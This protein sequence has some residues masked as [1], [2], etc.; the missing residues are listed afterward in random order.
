M[1][2][3]QVISGQNINA[4]QLDLV[5]ADA[6]GAGSLLVHQQLGAIALPTNPSNT[7]TLTLDINGTNVVITFVTSIGS[8]P[9]NVLISGV[10]A[11]ATCANLVAL[12]NQPQTTTATGVA[13]S[14]ANQTLVGYLS[15]PLAGTTITP[16]S[17]N[18]TLYAPETSFSAS[19][20]AT[21]GS[22]TAQ[23][24]QLYVEPGVFYIAGT[25]V[26]FAGGSTPTVTAPS[27]HPRIDVLSINASGTLSWTAGTENASPVAPTYPNPASN[28]VLCELYNVTGETQLLDN[29]NQSGAQ[30]YVSND[31]R[32]FQQP[33]M[34]WGA[35][36]TNLLPDADGTRDLGSASFEWNH[37]YVKSNLFVNGLA[38]SGHF[39][40]TGADGALTTASGTTTISAS[41]AAYLVKNYTSIS[42][43]GTAYVQFTTPHANGTIIQVKCQGNVVLT[44]SATPM[45]DASGM[46]A[47]GPTNAT[48]SSGSAGNQPNSNFFNATTMAGG[49]GSNAETAGTAGVLQTALII[50][51]VILGKFL[52]L[53]CGAGGGAGGGSGG[54][55]GHGGT[56][57]NGGGALYIECGGAF[58]FTT[59]SGISVAGTAGTNGTTYGGGGGGGG[60]GMLILLYASLTAN[61][62]TVTVSG[63]AAGNG[64]TSGGGSPDGGGGGGGASL[65][66]AGSIGSAGSGSGQGGNG[67]AGG[68]G[69][70]LIEANQDFS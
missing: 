6:A 54:S 21:G 55:G 42:I 3:Y 65:A 26:I 34:N 23:T 15:W 37:V 20:T 44:S 36:A 46:G 8:T 48:T 61:S 47:S 45:L 56:G 32:T 41:S 19:T 50:N 28:L 31:V 22:F 40:G 10:S 60:G 7:Q 4:Q 12:L 69:T 66:N 5:R 13:L 70:S 29:A 59:A 51:T 62:G 30:G 39:G 52:P 33:S 11:A 58:N 68:N 9:G 18:S 17:N 38:M 49:G 16:C 14:S 53:M 63:G 57:G 27:S 67:G 43:T 1:R 64:N 2:S 25:R 24:M 35:L